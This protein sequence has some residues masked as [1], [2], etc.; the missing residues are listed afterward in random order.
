MLTFRGIFVS[1]I[2]Y[3][4][5]FLKDLNNKYSCHLYDYLITTSVFV[6]L[7]YDESNLNVDG[8]K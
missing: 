7:L 4:M 8:C 1:N 2:K 6:L 3:S 5:F